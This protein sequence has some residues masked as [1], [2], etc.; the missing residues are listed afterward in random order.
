MYI[1]LH[2]NVSGVAASSQFVQSEIVVLHR[3]QISHLVEPHRKSY[4]YRSALVMTLMQLWV[5]HF[6]KS[7]EKN[8]INIFI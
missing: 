3:E 2:L 8:D 7:E 6:L 5:I 1:T 4:S